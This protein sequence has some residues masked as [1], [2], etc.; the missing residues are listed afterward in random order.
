MKWRKH[1]AIF[2]SSELNGLNKLCFGWLSEDPLHD[3]DS[4]IFPTV[5]LPESPPLPS[6]GAAESEK[7]LCKLAH[8]DVSANETHACDATYFMDFLGKIGQA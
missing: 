3:H 5:T 7:A 2:S 8:C 4:E 6:V 1:D